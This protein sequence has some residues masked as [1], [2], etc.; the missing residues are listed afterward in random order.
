[1]PVVTGAFVIPIELQPRRRAVVP[2]A[3][4]EDAFG[5]ELARLTDRL[6]Q[7]LGMDPRAVRAAL[8]A[9]VLPSDLE[10]DARRL[11]RAAC[12]R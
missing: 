12:P 10:A 11:R 2:P 3:K 9:G 8:A 4:L 1:M 7:D 6:A 5:V